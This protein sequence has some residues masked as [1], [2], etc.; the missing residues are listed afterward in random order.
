MSDSDMGDEETPTTD[1]AE[2]E[3]H[4]LLRARREKLEQLRAA[5]VNPYPYRFD[6]SHEV[7]ELRQLHDDWDAARLE[8][9]R[10]AARVK[11]R[12]MGLRSKGKTAFGHV[13][14]GSGRIQIYVRRDGVSEEDFMV[15]EM[16]DLG[17]IV[18]LDGH[19]MRTRTGELTLQVSALTLLCKT[20]R[21]IPIPKEEV[22]DGQRIVHDPFRDKELRYRQR[23]V[24]LVVNPEVRE[25]F[26][27]RTRI[28][29]TIRRILDERSFLEVETPIL[30]PLYGGAT[31]RPFTTHHNALGIQLYLRIANELYLK[32]LVVGGLERVYEFAKDF[33][34][35]GMDRFHNPEFTM[36]ELYQAYAD[37]GD[38]MAI[39]EEIVSSCA[40]EVAGTT[41][42]TFQGHELD[43]T[44][45]FRRLP[46][47]EG[48]EQYAGVDVKG[49]GREELLRMCA[50]LGIELTGSLDAWGVGK[51]ID[52]IFSAKVEPHL[53]QPTF[54][55]DFPV[56]T[57]PL[58]KRHRDDPALV[59]R[60]ECFIVR[61]ELCNAFSELNDP[62]D[63]RERF[64]AQM[65]LRDHGD[66]EAQMLDEDFLR[67]LEVGMPP[68][69]G[70]GIGIDRL[71][72]LLTDSPSIRDVVFF[73]QMRPQE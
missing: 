71:V 33:R 44:P 18:G 30:Q 31:A 15:F 67:A 38:M 55:T 16:L 6:A 73:P 32:R 21:P 57:S 65:A 37:Y 24:D 45:P 13:A 61:S 12:L 1:A 62:I 40:R 46:M 39:V 49:K 4:R 10:P 2:V 17:D 59:E 9:E 25:V 14:D 48:I 51:L 26:R 66:D 36:L 3:E 54:I 64:M 60:F 58:A 56:E 63:Q 5:G 53:V 47:V 8:A 41:H 23:Y 35:E 28:V 68:T 29:K 22:K 19:V 42:V 70:L 27:K 52:E 50:D 72:M 11:G 7:A 69:G 34:N 43:L 20:L